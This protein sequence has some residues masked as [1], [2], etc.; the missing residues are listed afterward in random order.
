MAMLSLDVWS[1]LSQGLDPLVEH[2]KHNGEAGQ[3]TQQKLPL[4][5]PTFVD[6]TCPTQDVVSDQMKR[7]TFRTKY[8]PSSFFFLSFICEHI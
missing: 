8:S 1:D 2:S 6:T 3:V 7:V 4:H 5:S